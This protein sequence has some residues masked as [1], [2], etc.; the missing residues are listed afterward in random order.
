VTIA[1][2]SVAEGN[3]GTK[4]A[5]FTVTL[6]RTAAQAVTVAYATAGGTAKS[7]AD[8]TAKSGTLT[9]GPG[10]TSQDVTVTVKGDKTAE[11]NEQF[12]VRLTA[13]SANATILRAAATGTI[14]DDDAEKRP[15]PKA[16]S[17]KVT[18]KRDRTS[19]Y[20][21]TVKGAVSRPS[22][23]KSTA[24]KGGRVLVQ[25]V[26]GGKVV[27]TKRLTLKTCSYSTKVTLKGKRKALR[28]RVRFLGTKTLAPFGPKEVAVTTG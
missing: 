11:K 8:F 17:E 18:P 5:R 15:R 21:F 6:S 28:L 12:L 27:A 19:P 25:A 24:C 2:A 4:A 20:A 22:G 16:L 9:F 23:V 3:G 1:D 26:A 10:Q 7:P 14:L 13:V